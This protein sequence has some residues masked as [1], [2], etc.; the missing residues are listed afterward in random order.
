[1]GFGRMVRGKSGDERFLER[2]LQGAKSF[3]RRF[4]LLL[5]GK[6]QAIAEFQRPTCHRSI[7]CI[8]EVQYASTK[9]AKNTSFIN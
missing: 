7:N 8:K 9:N 1:M 2:G 5:T 4:C 6:F 3:F